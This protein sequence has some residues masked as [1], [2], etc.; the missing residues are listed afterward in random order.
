MVRSIMEYSLTVW[1]PPTSSI[2]INCLESVQRHA[3]RMC[4]KNFS[5]YSSVTSLLSELN[6][7]TLQD[8]RSRAKLQ[9]M[10]KIIHHLVAI[11]D[12]CLTP[13]PSYL[14]SWYFNQLNTNVDSFKFSLLPSTIKSWNQLLRNITDSTTCTKFCKELDNWLWLHLIFYD[15]CTVII[16]ISNQVPNK[17]KVAVR[18]SSWKGC[19]KYDESMIN[20]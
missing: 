5:R 16:I 14:Q 7:S 4:F 11:P 17:I 19:N 13:A 2:N 6:F 10:Y 9:M 3:A 15:S 12:D 20:V 8:R 18:I 1:D